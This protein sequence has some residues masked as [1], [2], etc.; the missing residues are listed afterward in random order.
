MNA[1]GIANFGAGW[2]EPVKAATEAAKSGDWLS[3]LGQLS[4]AI[5]AATSVAGLIGKATQ[6][7]PEAAKPGLPAA[8]A[9][10]G[11]QQSGVYASPA[12]A[13]FMGRQNNDTDKRQSAALAILGSR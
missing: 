1:G 6:D 10:A 8:S 9:P 2:V 7:T 3:I 12:G 13:P 11:V 4:P 5:D